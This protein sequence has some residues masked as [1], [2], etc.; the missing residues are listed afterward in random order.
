VARQFSRLRILS[1]LLA[2]KEQ[3]RFPPFRHVGRSR[4]AVVRRVSR[5]GQGT[6]SRERYARWRS[7]FQQRVGLE[8]A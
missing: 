7:K 2:R 1:F 5:W 4:S 3:D 8:E 6:R